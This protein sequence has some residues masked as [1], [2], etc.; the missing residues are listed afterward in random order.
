LPTLFP[1]C[2][3]RG[4]SAQRHCTRFRRLVDSGRVSVGVWRLRQWLQDG[5]AIRRH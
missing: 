4:Q 1:R 5:D 2:P 3:A